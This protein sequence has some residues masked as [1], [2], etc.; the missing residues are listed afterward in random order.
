MKYPPAFGWVPNIPELYLMHL[1]RLSFS[2]LLCLSF[3]D[4][5]GQVN[6]MIT[7]T[8]NQPMDSVVTLMVPPTSLG[9]ESRNVST[10]LTSAGE[11]RIAIRTNVATPAVIAHG[12]GSI[13]IFIVPDR[14]FSLEFTAEDGEAKEV[15][16]AGPGGADNAFFHEYRQFLEEEAPLI[17][18]GR[19]AR[20]T[21]R[22]YRRLMDQNRA[23][24]EGFW[25]RYSRTADIEMAP[26][27]LQWLRNDIVYTYATELLRYPSVFRDLHKGTKSR[28]PS[29]NYYSF[30]EGIP[31]NLLTKNEIHRL[32][33]M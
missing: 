29:T 13:P 12:G 4:L 14:S 28:S 18:S 1:C 26:Q 25:E 9:G 3:S 31:L 6:V 21:A 23:A 5:S 16:F 2:L 27:V 17:D 22:E 11:F 24:R 10:R 19:L 30:L 33:C 32:F 15:L 8:V 20:S 7:G